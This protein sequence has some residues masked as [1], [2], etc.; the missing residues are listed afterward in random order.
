M[1]IRKEDSMHLSEISSLKEIYNDIFK[2]IK[3]ELKGK[4]PTGVKIYSPSFEGYAN[5]NH[6]HWIYT[7]V[8]ELLFA[9]NEDE[10]TL[11]ELRLKISPFSIEENEQIHEFKFSVTIPVRVGNMEK[12]S[13]VFI[14]TTDEITELVHEMHLYSKQSAQKKKAI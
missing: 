12:L 13:E 14:S 3:H 10:F 6:H 1:K 9:W 2:K 11:H 8:N 5:N 7:D 4:L